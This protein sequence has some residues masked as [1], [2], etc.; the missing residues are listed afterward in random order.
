MVLLYLYAKPTIIIP[1]ESGNLCEV[2]G[3]PAFA[4][5]T[6]LEYLGK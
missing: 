5:M 1:R 3:I 4:G 6:D 2:V